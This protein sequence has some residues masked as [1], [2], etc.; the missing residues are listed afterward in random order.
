MLQGLLNSTTVPLLE[1]V[2]A[3]TERRQD[4]LA[5]NIA[6]IDTP[7]YKM[8]DLPVA[9]F[10]NAL[11]RAIEARHRVPSAADLSP[12]GTPANSVDRHFSEKLFQA[13]EAPPANVTFSRQDD[14]ELDD[15]AVRHRIDDRPVEYAAFG[16]QRTSLTRPKNKS[17]WIKKLVTHCLQAVAGQGEPEVSASGGNF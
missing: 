4:V 10:Q 1:K 9:D 12:E 14:Q 13:I 5:G 16:D 8:R 17:E 7:D 3:F 6:N 15:A 11:T 2:A